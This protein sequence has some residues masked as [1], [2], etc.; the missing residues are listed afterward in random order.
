MAVA[1]LDLVAE[2]VEVVA[3]LLGTVEV[4]VEVGVRLLGAQV[5]GGGVVKGG[6]MVDVMGETVG[7]R[8]MRTQLVTGKVVNGEGTVAGTQGL[9]MQPAKE[10]TPIAK[11]LAQNLTRSLSVVALCTA[12]RWGSGHRCLNG[13]S[14]TCDAY[15]LRS[16][17]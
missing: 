2:R 11:T 10:A 3:P 12:L 15:S 13:N 9:V 1:L 16:L 14:R 7:I 6:G 4:A 17:R 8:L 5:V